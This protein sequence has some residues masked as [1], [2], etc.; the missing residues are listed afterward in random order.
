MT[1]VCVCVSWCPV[2]S[3]SAFIVCGL[4]K[5]PRPLFDL[6][7]H[8]SLILLR[9]STLL[10]P[11]KS[12]FFLFYLFQFLPKLDEKNQQTVFVCLC[13]C[14]CV[15]YF[16]WITIWWEKKQSKCKALCYCRAWTAFRSCCRRCCCSSSSRPQRQ[17]NSF[18]ASCCI[19]F[20]FIFFF[21]AFNWVSLL[22]LFALL[23]F[24]ALFFSIRVRCSF[25][26]TWILQFYT[27]LKLRILE[28]KIFFFLLVWCDFV[29]WELGVILHVKHKKTIVEPELDRLLLDS[30]LTPW[31]NL[32]DSK[33]RIWNWSILVVFPCTSR[34]TVQCA[35]CS[36]TLTLIRKGKRRNVRSSGRWPQTNDDAMRCDALRCDDDAFHFLQATNKPTTT[37]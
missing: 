36:H 20:H 31:W 34:R 17:V 10:L 22:L 33:K 4:R 14:A 18:F 26:F 7:R 29:A 21:L 37:F 3:I 23:P 12:S 27:N 2:T 6:C 5:S 11:L 16:R 13:V 30:S 15:C 32:F 35:V 1:A 19:L 25:F 9:R 28:L 8:S 24:G